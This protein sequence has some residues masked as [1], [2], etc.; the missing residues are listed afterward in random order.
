MFLVRSVPVLLVDPERDRDAGFALEPNF[1]WPHD[2]VPT[3]AA[4]ISNLNKIVHTDA[5]P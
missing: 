2:I 1:I 3:N 5:K 4:R